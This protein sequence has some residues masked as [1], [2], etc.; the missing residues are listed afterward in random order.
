[1]SLNV[2]VTDTYNSKPALG[3]TKNDLGLF[4]GVNVKFGAL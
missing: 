1:L 3:F 4:T 2:G